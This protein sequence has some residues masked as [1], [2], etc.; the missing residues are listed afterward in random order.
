MKLGIYAWHALV[1]SLEMKCIHVYT[2]VSVSHLR[3]YF[4]SSSLVHIDFKPLS[5]YFQESLSFSQWYSFKEEL[6]S[7]HITVSKCVA[8]SFFIKGISFCLHLSSLN[9]WAVVKLQKS[10]KFIP[11]HSG[12]TPWNIHT[13]QNR[14]HHSSLHS[15]TFSKTFVS[16]LGQI[17]TVDIQN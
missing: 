2:I 11:L 1:I 5:Y 16:T 17:S 4:L 14:E 8:Y 13:K 7:F 3:E 10:Y 9:K 6:I 12:V 15:E